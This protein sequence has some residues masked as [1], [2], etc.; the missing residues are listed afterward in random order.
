MD[1]AELNL[2]NSSAFKISAE[3]LS[4]EQPWSGQLSPLEEMENDHYVAFV[5]LLDKCV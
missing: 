1:R 4:E 3:L 5:L 2:N